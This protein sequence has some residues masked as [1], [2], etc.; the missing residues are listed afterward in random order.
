MKDIEIENKRELKDREKLLEKLRENGFC[1]EYETREIDTYFSRPDVDFMKTVECL[2]IREKPEFCE[3]TYKPATSAK[4]AHDGAI[5]KHE[6]NV[7]IARAEI[8][9][10]KELLANLEMRELCVVDKTRVAFAN[11]KFANLTV[12]IDRL[13]GVGDFVETE[14]IS[15][16]ETTALKT[17]AKIEKLLEIAKFPAV[18]LPYRDLTMRATAKN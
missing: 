1:E 6:T 13:A 18:K 12:A 3:L 16:N 5:L 9:R 15:R 7:R 17:L 4:T 14:M 10:L 2:R 11:P 8:P